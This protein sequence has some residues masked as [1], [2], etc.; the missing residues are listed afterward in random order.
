MICERGVVGSMTPAAHW[1]YVLVPKRVR[2]SGPTSTSSDKH[3]CTPLT[4][5][6]VRKKYRL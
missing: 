2:S 5:S 3:L 1:T 4:H 6:K